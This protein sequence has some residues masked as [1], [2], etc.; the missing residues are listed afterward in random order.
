MKYTL[1]KCS[2]PGWEKPFS[3]REEAR[4]ELLLHICS[5][6]LAGDSETETPAPDVSDIWSLLGTPCGCEY[7]YEETEL[8][9]DQKD[10]KLGQ[11][12]QVIADLL[13]ESTRHDAERV[14]DY[15]AS[16]EFDPDFLPWPREEA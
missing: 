6:C 4:A 13:V 15:F 11:A 5:G 10:E 16:D 1:H 2:S 14:L 8:T 7:D 9:H 12:Y 3:G